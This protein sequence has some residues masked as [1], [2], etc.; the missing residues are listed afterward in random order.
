[1]Y[2]LIIVDDEPFM[3]ES[4]SRIIEWDKIGFEVCGKFANGKQAVEFIENNDVD[5]VLTDIKM[6]LMDG[7]ELCEYLYKN[8]PQ[9]KPVIISGHQDFEFARQAMKY[10]VSDYLLKPT[11]YGEIIQT[12]KNIRNQLDE[13]KREQHQ[14]LPFIA[15]Q[16][17]FDLFTGAMQNQKKIGEYFNMIGLDPAY[18]QNP[19]I[20]AVLRM[21]DYENYMQ[22]VWKHDLDG[23]STAIWQ[24]FYN[25]GKDISY[26]FFNKEE[27]RFWIAGVNGKADMKDSVMTFL[28]DKKGELKELL[29]ADFDVESIQ[30]FSS[31]FELSQYGRH[32]EQNE[33]ENTPSSVDAEYKKLII[34]YI[35]LGDTEAVNNLLNNYYGSQNIEL[36]TAKTFNIELLKKLQ[37]NLNQM[38]GNINEEIAVFAQCSDME[39]VRIKSRLVFMQIAAKINSNAATSEKLL[40]N[41]AKEYIDVNCC[42]DISLE[43]VANSIYVSPVYISRLFKEQTGQNFI[44]YLVELRMKKAMELLKDHRLKVYEVSEQVGYKSLKYFYK[45]FKRYTG[46][47][48]TEYRNQ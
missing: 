16:F 28:I 43:S 38:V 47:T 40:I 6:P 2:K 12:F 3:L 24:I 8:A 27:D 41:K 19:C 25:S 29:N 35:N 20:I 46:V 44:D 39:T 17:F 11:R 18:A 26:Y 23:F 37:S 21:N 1:M 10:N 48:P 45:L 33:G 32:F 34:Y 9:I 7:L 13:N 30:F 4:I 14:L 5:V 15:R 36:E 22:T 42:F 31:V